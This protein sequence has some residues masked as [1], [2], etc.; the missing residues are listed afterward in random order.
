MASKLE[1][2][3]LKRGLRS[4]HAKGIIFLTTLLFTMSYLSLMGCQTPTGYRLEADKVTKTIIQEKQIHAL[5]KKEEFDIERPSDTLR[6]R[7]LIGQHLPYSGE[8]SL[9]VDK[10]KTIKHWPEKDYP[11]SNSSSTQTLPL[12]PGRPL[13]LSLLQALKIGARNS[14]EYQTQKEEVFQ[15]ALNLD[16]ERKE[17]RTGFSGQVEGLVSSDL[18]G[19]STVTGTET[20][21]SFGA[22]KTLKSGAELSAALAVDLVKLL[23]QDL[24]SSLGIVGDATIAIPLLRGSGSHI[25]TEPLTQAERNVVYAVYEFERFKKAFAVNIASDYLEVLQ[26][27]DEVANASENYRNLIAS[28]R[29]SRRLADA[30][31][32]TEIEV[33]QAL[34]NE[35]RAR[36]R[37]VTAQESYKNNLDSFKSLLGLPPDAEIEMDGSE[38]DK[39]LA[40]TSK[41]MEDIAREEELSA[42]K[43]TP[44]ADAPI[45][46]V[47]PGRDDAGPFE[48]DAPLAI[49][50]GLQNRLDL[51]VAEGKV[52]DAQRKVVV[53]A[54]ALRAELTLFGSAKLGESRSIATADLDNTK[55]RTGKGIYSALLTI[56][57]PFERTAERNAYRNSFISLEQAVRDV[58]GLEDEIK[59]LIRKRLRDM[60]ESRESLKIQARALFL[61]QKRVKSTNLFY[62]AGRTQIRDVLEAQEALISSKNGL[63]SAAA[64]YRIAE[65]EFQRDTGLLK[66]DEKG[67]WKE[68]VPEGIKN[69]K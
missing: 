15:T 33:D 28:T 19:E 5:G 54:D 57:L 44:P 20:S 65:L 35:L 1:K 16:L 4:L 59:L 63:T 42:K 48:M 40:P 45:E 52:Y 36:N 53:Y 51:R 9:G 25:I 56:D 50:L 31:R 60:H 3:I 34:Q 2:I 47:K 6:R 22:S 23:T 69:V 18:S 30:G 64:A 38:L 29:R 7:L 68:Y 26:R 39:L 41:T 27:L 24:S 8:A 62:D 43:R 17:F 61:A 21:G 55:F 37:W 10:L 66:I 11:M 67:L 12:E 58:Q 46:L 32:V 14:F 49:K 13:Q